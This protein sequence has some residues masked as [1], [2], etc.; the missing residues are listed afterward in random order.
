MT[1]SLDLLTIVE[2]RKQF[3]ASVIAGSSALGGPLGVVLRACE[4][5]S[6]RLRRHRSKDSI[7]EAL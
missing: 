1:I 6:G 5:Q 4:S 7:L 3:V 2:T